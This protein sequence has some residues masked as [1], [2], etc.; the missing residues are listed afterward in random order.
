MGIALQNWL[1]CIEAVFFIIFTF[2]AFP[3]MSTDRPRIQSRLTKDADCYTN[4]ICVKT[5]TGPNRFRK[6]YQV[7]IIDADGE[8]IE[9]NTIADISKLD[10]A[11]ILQNQLA[12]NHQKD[13]AVLVVPNDEFPAHNFCSCCHKRHTYNQ[14]VAL[15]SKG[16]HRTQSVERKLSAADE[17]FEEIG[18][19]AETRLKKSHRVEGKKILDMLNEGAGVGTSE[20]KQY[21][22]RCFYAAGLAE[23]ISVN[24]HVQKRNEIVET[25]GSVREV[26]SQGYRIHWKTGSETKTGTSETISYEDFHQQIDLTPP[27][28]KFQR[29]GQLMIVHIGSTIKGLFEAAKKRE[30][31]WRTLFEK[32]DADAIF[33]KFDANEDGKLDGTE[34]AFLI[35]VAICSNVP[36]A[37][38]M[39]A[40]QK[41]RYP[42]GTDRGKFEELITICSSPNS[43]SDVVEGGLTAPLMP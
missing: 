26:T 14:I 35:K 40:I 41:E 33:N 39:L 16:A 10:D 12:H 6:G 15:V 43:R 18:K 30:T 28:Y 42:N 32:G 36:K 37:T 5:P 9:K 24:Q 2:S 21:H 4:T 8:A 38:E 13:A 22:A 17:S 19:G 27:E 29:C 31:E 34:L 1:I 7:V 20:E 3:A 11:L 25:I 23:G